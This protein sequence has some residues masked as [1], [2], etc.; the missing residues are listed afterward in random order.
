MLAG[1]VVVVVPEDCKIQ[2]SG[3]KAVEV[4]SEGYKLPEMIQNPAAAE[5][6]RKLQIAAASKSVGKL[7]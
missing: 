3:M 5:G 7:H 6:Y 1:S 4:E 2:L